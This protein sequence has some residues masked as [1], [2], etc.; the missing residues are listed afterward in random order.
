MNDDRLENE[1]QRKVIGHIY[2]V[3]SRRGKDSRYHFKSRE[4][5]KELGLSSNEL[6]DALQHISTVTKESPIYVEHGAGVIVEQWTSGT[7][8]TWLAR[9]A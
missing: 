9:I 5:A 2:S 6:G 1:D 4:I 3:L 8:A 7:P